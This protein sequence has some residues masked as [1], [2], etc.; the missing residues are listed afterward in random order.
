MDSAKTWRLDDTAQIAH[1]LHRILRARIVQNDL[2]PGSKV[3]ETA[4]AVQYGISRQ[5]VR[6]AFIK[7]ADQNL[8]EIRPKRSTEISKIDMAAVLDARFVRE[9]IEADIVKILARTGDDSLIQELH[10][11]LDNQRAAAHQDPILFAELDDQFHQTLAHACDKSNAWLFTASLKTQMDRVRFLSLDQDSTDRIIRQHRDIADAIAK[12]DPVAAEQAL[13]QH[14]QE[15]IS[16][17]PA[18][19]SAYPDHFEGAQMRAA[20]TL[21]S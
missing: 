7:L 8:I 9:A 3:S 1:D 17:L 19:Q 6:E 20:Q 18:V 12:R 15:I 2:P 21:I 10:D 5:P 13:R 16:D 14:L 4:I 11:Q